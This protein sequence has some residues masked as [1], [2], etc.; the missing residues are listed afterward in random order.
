MGPGKG[1]EAVAGRRMSLR[2][3]VTV[4]EIGS[5]DE[6]GIDA[7]DT[8]LVRVMDPVCQDTAPLMPQ[9]KPKIHTRTVF[10][11]KLRSAPLYYRVFRMRAF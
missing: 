2:G 5:S 4:E 1:I 9:E 11:S 10:F 6:S 8:W 3:G 7:A